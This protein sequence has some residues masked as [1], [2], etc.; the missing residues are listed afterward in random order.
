MLLYST[1]TKNI[2]K[3]SLKYGFLY[4]VQDKESLESE[5]YDSEESVEM[6]Y[7]K[8][9]EVGEVEVEEEEKGGEE[10]E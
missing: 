7:P 8:P 2:F 10:D 9:I 1:D 6:R 5:Y 3:K 4:Q